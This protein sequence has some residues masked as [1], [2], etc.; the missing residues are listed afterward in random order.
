MTRTCKSVQGFACRS[1]LLIL[2]LV[3]LSNG[4]LHSGELEDFEKNARQNGGK[5]NTEGD[6]DL[7][8]GKSKA[9]I[10][11]M[12]REGDIAQA[13][14]YLPMY[15]L[16]LAVASGVTSVYRLSA[17]A[18][19]NSKYRAFPETGRGFIKSGVYYKSIS[20]YFQPRQKGDA[21]LSFARADFDHTWLGNNVS[22]LG[23][24]VELGLGPLSLDYHYRHFLQTEPSAYYLNMN[25]FNF[26][27]RMSFSNS[28]EI[29][30]GN[31]M[32]NMAGQENRWGYN[33]ELPVLFQPCEYFSLE[34]RPC[35]SLISGAMYSE[36]SLDFLPSIRYVALKL[37]YFWTNNGNVLLSG[38]HAGVSVR[39]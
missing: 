29:I 8:K 28:L 15:Y 32:V 13:I 34:A 24:F 21:L 14:L 6:R 35:W 27:W 4:L 3:F 30:F 25:R 33:L 11:Q 31:G 10:W 19:D 7:Y 12:Q 1:M 16:V 18:G 17:K 9:E 26:G 39:Y 38:P 37:G 23:G 36:Y 5:V 20:D 22:A 2:T